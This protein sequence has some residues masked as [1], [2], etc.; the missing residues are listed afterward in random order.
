MVFLPE[1]GKLPLQEGYMRPIL[2]RMAAVVAIAAVICCAAEAGGRQIRV[3]LQH[4]QSSHLYENLDYFKQLVEKGTNGALKIVIAHSGQL[5]NEQDAPEAVAT[6]RCEMASVAVNQYAGVIPAADLFVQPF[7]FAHP[8][9]LAAATQPGSPVRA[10][11]DQAILEHVAARV[12]WWQSSGTTVMVSKTPL[13]TPA[14]IA[15]KKVRVSTESE[16]EFVRLCGG[17]PRV[18]PAAAQFDAYDS[19]E[20]IAGSTTIAAVPVRRFWEVTKFVT[21]TRHRTSEFVVTINERLWQSLSTEQRRVLEEAAREAEIRL[22]ERMRAIEREAYALA[23][24]NGMRM[25]ELTKAREQDQWKFCAA[26]MVE[27]YLDRAGELGAR[28]MSGYRKLLVE[29]IA[30]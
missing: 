8:P 22:R 7:M 6:G 9:V 13:T 4:P 17:I 2:S 11:I 16:G 29:N 21:F 18:I 14:A 28:V 5:I 26:P 3:A 19:D 12:L 10:P 23:E 25:V 27:A 30:R 1:S 24:K 15:G 20:L